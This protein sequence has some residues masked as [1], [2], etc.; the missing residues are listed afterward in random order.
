MSAPCANPSLT[1]PSS[2]TSRPWTAPGLEAEM[3]FNAGADYVVV[4]G[5]AHDASIIEQVKMAQR[6]GGKVMCD[7]M[8]CADKPGRAKEAQD[9]GVDVII[10]HTG[11]DERAMIPGLSPLDDLPAILAAVDIP[12]QAV[13]GLT[14][15]QAIETLELGAEIVVFGAPLVIASDAFT[16]ATDDFEGL[17]REIVTQVKG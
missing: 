3:M 8:L 12:V 2:P 16:A 15:E 14:V 11:F 1:I 4:M 17:L 9:M 5:V 13:G 10:V 6:C 7:V